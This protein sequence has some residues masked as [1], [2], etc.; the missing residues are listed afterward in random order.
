MLNLNLISLVN[1]RVLNKDLRLSLFIALCMIIIASL[2]EVISIG[3]FLPFVE[4]LLNGK[5]GFINNKVID[6][7]TFIKNYLIRTSEKEIIN[8]GIIFFCSIVVFKNMLVFSFYYYREHIFFKL[9]TSLINRL[10]KNI[11]LKNFE[12]FYKKNSSVYYN[13]LIR[14][15]GQTSHTINVFLHL[16]N[17]FIVLIFVV[18]F[19]LIIEPFVT[20]LLILIFFILSFP[21]YFFTKE[22]IKSMSVERIKKDQNMVQNINESF[23]LFK[24]LKVNFLEKIFL[25]L[26][27]NN[28]FRS[29]YLKKNINILQFFPRFYLEAITIIIFSAILL[30]INYNRNSLIEILPII[31]VFSFAGL[32]LLP[33]IKS[34]VLGLQEVK[35]GSPSIRTV[36]DELIKEKFCNVEFNDKSFK[37][38]QVKNLSFNYSKNIKLINDFNIEIEAG[39]K[40]LVKGV[41]GSGKTTLMDVLIG[42]KNYQ[43]GNILLDEQ[44]LNDSLFKAVRTSYIPQQSYLI[45]DSI[46][47]NIIFPIKNFNEETYNK[48]IKVVELDKLIKE[49]PSKDDTNLGENGLKIS[50]G[51]KQRIIIARSLII[52]PKILI[53]DEATNALDVDA[54]NSIINNIITN[55]KK[56][57]IFIISH[58]KLE[59]K[60]FSKTIKVGGTI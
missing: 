8:L 13:L 41:S 9:Q 33:L 57:T 32:R 5:E 26:F 24:Y 16:L 27:D 42:I 55:F 1:N 50:G 7:N 11:L 21:V 3:S 35:K 12:N 29:F 56:M 47:K 22:K 58:R 40:I 43:K 20:L 51:Q 37:K 53:F 2:L 48:I 10:F 38:I 52:Q 4:I 6:Q 36:C 31:A 49:L 44:P 30:F 45:D 17:E 19:L 54:E 60:L 14:E 46:K 39:D 34:F 25:K 23:S 59:E 28:I 15:A 18:S